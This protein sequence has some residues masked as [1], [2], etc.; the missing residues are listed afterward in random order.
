MFVVHYMPDHTH[1]FVEYS[2]SW[3]RRSLLIFKTLRGFGTLEG[4][5][6]SLKFIFPFPITTVVISF[7]PLLH[8]VQPVGKG[9]DKLAGPALKF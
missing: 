5:F 4:K 7:L 3:L 9:Y 8:P 1:L 6:D 2:L